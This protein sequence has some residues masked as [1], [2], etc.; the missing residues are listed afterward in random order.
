[1]RLGPF[2]E[3]GNDQEVAGKLHARDDAQLEVETLGVVAGGE[4][5]RQALDSQAL[6]QALLGLT[7]ELQLF[8]RRLVAVWGILGRNEARQD[9]LARQRTIRAALRDLDGAFERL[10]K[11]GEQRGH[12]VGALEIVLTG[13]A[14]AL[15]LRHHASFGDA[16][17]CVVGLVI[18][19]LREVDL[20]GSDERDAQ[21]V[22]QRDQLRLD[23]LLGFEAV[24]LQ[25]DVK[26]AVEY[27]GK[28]D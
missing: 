3:V 11:I 5:F 8:G 22:S 1:V 12:V 20:V 28:A 16:E 2:D 21:L 4:S 24:A 17:Q 23:L 13:H 15:V 10:W 6:A 7:L 9:R 26:L 14:A 19:G 25:L 18:V 27:A